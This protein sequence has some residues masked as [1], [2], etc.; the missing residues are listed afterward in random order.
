MP[1]PSPELRPRF[2]TARGM[3]TPYAL[4]CGYIQRASDTGEY[5]TAGRV[6]DLWHEGACYHVRAHDHANGSRLFWDSF[7]TLT[8]AREHWRT[9]RRALCLTAHP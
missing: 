1:T 9:Q 2:R 5:R 3:L 4:A 7:P 6:L 8:E